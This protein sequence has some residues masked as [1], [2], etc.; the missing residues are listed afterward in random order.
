MDRL[1]ARGYRSPPIRNGRNGREEGAF[2]ARQTTVATLLLLASLSGCFPTSQTA[3]VPA[4]PFGDGAMTSVPSNTGPA[5]PAATT[6]ASRNV[7]R[8]GQKVVSAN[9]DLGL[10]PY[11]ITIGGEAARPELFHSGED[12]VFI[13][14]T[15]A[16]QCTT[17]GQLA[18]LL[19]TELARIISERNAFRFA[20][21]PDNGPPPAV[22]P[23][24]EYG[25]AFGPADGTRMMELAKYERK[26][27]E[28]GAP[29]KPLPPDVLA[30]AYL[31]QAGYNPSDVDAVAG[32]LRTAGSN[33]RFEKQLS[34]SFL[35]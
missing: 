23:G 1:C 21:L 32:L 5:A 16:R 34:G 10:H 8:V 15:L 22:S 29:A 31:K 25:G 14:E 2:M 4:S 13:T 24:N 7:L 20:A 28:A 3:L 19:S 26:R 35:K 17:E 6:E 33:S 9:P 11:F 27:T 30:R 18:A 12:K